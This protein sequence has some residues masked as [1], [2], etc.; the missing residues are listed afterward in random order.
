MKYLMLLENMTIYIAEGERLV[1]NFASSPAHLTYHPEY[2]WRWVVKSLNNGYRALLDDEGREELEEITTYWRGKSVHGMERDYLPSDVRPYWAFNGVDFW[3]HFAESGVPSYEKIFNVGLNGIINE[4][5]ERLGEIGKDSS[6]STE[7]YIEKKDFLEAVIISLTAAID[8]ARRYADEA[9]Q[10]AQEEKDNN[11]KRELEEIAETCDWVPGNPPRT[12]HEALQSFFFI[13][14][15]THLIEAYEN[16]VGVRFDLLFYPFYK[17]DKEEGRITPEGAQELLEFLWLKMEEMT[18]LFAPML[19]G[20]VQGS[21][22]FQT[23]TIGGVTPQGEDAVNELTYI[24]LDACDAMALSQPTTAIRIHSQT[25]REFILRVINSIRKR[26][27][28]VSLFNDDYVIPRLLGW[29]IPLED[30]RNYGIEQCMRWAIPGKNIVYRAVDGII[31]LPG[32]LELALNRGARFDGQKLG[33]DTPDPVSFSS[34]EDVIKAFIEQ[35][36]F[37]VEKVARVANTADVLYEQYLPRPFLSAV[38]D[39]GIKQG[40]DCRKWFYYPKRTMGY[41]GAS[42]VADALAA[43]KKLIFEEKKISMERLLNALENNW[44]GEEEL[45]QMFINGAVKYGN[46]DDYV[47]LLAKEVHCKVSRTIE[48]VKNYYGHHFVVDG[49]VGSTYYAF[50]SLT[51]ATP[52]GRKY[53]DLFNDGTCSPC[54]SADRKGPTATL[55]SVAKLDPLASHNLLLN[56]KFLRHFLEEENKELFAD[57]LKTWH[58]LGIHHIQFNIV[59]Q[60]TLLDAQEHPETHSDLVVR[61]A[62]YAAYF[63]DLSQKLQYEII[64]RA[65]QGFC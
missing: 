58:D 38:L 30:T 61:V 1:G 4:A 37:V 50:S 40:R 6:L 21:N 27:G 5:K 62:G 54:P 51:G 24:V 41:I 9:R 23:L 65:E 20:G 35:V 19:G 56:Q 14:L 60:D 17:K 53:A 47:D 11:R 3:G 31:V 59:D 2:Y 18:I 46:D 22:L 28:T 55:K 39:D 29:G 52:D 26:W 33:V 63:V 49:S 64:H 8:W 25:S 13:H 36:R 15:I 43:M 10:L 16:G 34:I 32:C 44:V 48:S 57:Y 7:D 12:L 45:R 42:N